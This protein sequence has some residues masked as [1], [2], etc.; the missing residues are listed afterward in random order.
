MKTILLVFVPAIIAGL[1]AVTLAQAPRNAEI[2]QVETNKKEASRLFKEAAELL[3]GGHYA[4]ACP[5]L[6]E[7]RRLNPKPGTLYALAECEVLL[8]RILTAKTHYY[9]FFS[10][11]QELP[12]DQQKNYEDRVDN[13][14]NKLI[15]IERAIPKIRFVI[16]PNWNPNSIVR[17]DGIVFDFGK[18]QNTHQ[19]DPGDHVVATQLNG[20]PVRQER[21]AVKKGEVW[22]LLLRVDEPPTN[23]ANAANTPK[24]SEAP[25]EIQMTTSSPGLLNSAPPV[26]IA[27]GA[28]GL[29]LLTIALGVAASDMKNTD[30]QDQL[31]YTFGITGIVGV[32]VG[33]GVTLGVSKPPPTIR[34]TAWTR[35]E[36][37]ISPQGASFGLRGAF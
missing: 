35:P 24:A 13:A 34:Q 19:V 27:C 26:A 20:G 11:V 10:M 37:N 15:E 9:E 36:L 21:Y 29:V 14:T 33:V 4:E 3:D 17:V 5:K 2:V 7:S 25:Q 6:M 1:P 8:D 28:S 16:P 22:T 31:A 12:L 30:L 32:L 23:A 18:L